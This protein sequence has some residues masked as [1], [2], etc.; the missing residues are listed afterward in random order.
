MN[1]ERESRD[2]GAIAIETGSTPDATDPEGT[3]SPQARLVEA[4]RK[5]PDLN[6]VRRVAPRNRVRPSFALTA[7]P[8]L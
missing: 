1:F 5:Q 6:C 8:T 3:V 4:T 7:S 2:K